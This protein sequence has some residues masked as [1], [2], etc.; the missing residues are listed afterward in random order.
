MGVWTF[1]SFLLSEYVGSRLRFGENFGPCSWSA[2]SSKVTTPG[3]SCLY[4]PERAKYTSPGCSGA[5]M[6]PRVGWTFRDPALQ[7]RN[8][9]RRT[10]MHSDAQLRL[11]TRDRCRAFRAAWFV[12][13]CGVYS[14]NLSVYYKQRCPFGGG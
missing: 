6:K 9:N 7:G 8:T 1:N 11:R 4:S 2:I 10:G 12:S 5:A 14:R 3:R 13:E